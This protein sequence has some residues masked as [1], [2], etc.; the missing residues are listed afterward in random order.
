MN[1]DKE[2]YDNATK[3][4][5][6]KWLIAVIVVVSV[7]AIVLIIG[8]VVY[9]FV[10]RKQN[11]QNKILQQILL[12]NKAAADQAL[13]T[14]E[15]LNSFLFYRTK[16]IIFF[17]KKFFLKNEKLYSMG[18]QGSSST[19]RGGEATMMNTTIGQGICEFISLFLYDIG[20][21]NR[22]N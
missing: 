3:S 10:F 15:V 7:L 13:S 6:P 11:A 22:I 17:K 8:L 18:I 2:A 9:L 4:E 14:Y 20:L 5:F 16:I 19:L 1:I 21:L 12:P